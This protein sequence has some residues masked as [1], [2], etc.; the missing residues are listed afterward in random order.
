MAY[1]ISEMFL[2]MDVCFYLFV[3]RGID[4]STFILDD[5]SD[6]IMDS[7]HGLKVLSGKIDMF[8]LH[9]LLLS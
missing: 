2:A 3:V 7:I 4:E 5:V 1:S 6:G 9:R 8:L